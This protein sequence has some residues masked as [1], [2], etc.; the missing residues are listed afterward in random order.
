MS[1]TTTDAAAEIRAAYKARG[2]TDRQIGVRANYFSLGSS[3]DITIKDGQIPVHEAKKIA[4]GKERISR[5]EMTGEI[6]GGGNRYVSVSVSQA[7]QQLKARRY[8]EAV[9]AAIDKLPENDG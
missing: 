2:W 5:C 3:I 7:A 4:E 9:E 8:I 1:G 6:L